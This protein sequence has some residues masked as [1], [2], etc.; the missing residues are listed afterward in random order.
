MIAEKQ[1]AERK[2]LRDKLV[3]LEREL[4]YNKKRVAEYRT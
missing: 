1:D 2:R 4:D 3:K